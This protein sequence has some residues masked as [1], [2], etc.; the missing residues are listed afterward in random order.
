M[1]NVDRSLRDC[2]CNKLNM[3]TKIYEIVVEMSHKLNIS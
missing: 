1:T 3:E 2:V